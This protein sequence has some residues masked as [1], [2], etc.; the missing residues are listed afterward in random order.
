MLNTGK[1]SICH[2]K[3]IITIQL[4]YEFCKHLGDFRSKAHVRKSQYPH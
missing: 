3:K 4:Y 1:I 2:D